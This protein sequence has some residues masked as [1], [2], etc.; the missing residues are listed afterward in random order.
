MRYPMLSTLSIVTLAAA[1][2]AA[3]AAP[4]HAQLQD[5]T[6]V[7]PTNDLP[8]PY[9]RV[10]PWGELPDP[11][12]PGAY[13]ERAAFIGADEGPDGN[14]YLLGRCLQNSC[15]GRSEPPLLKLDPSGRLLLSWGSGLFDFPHG[16]DLDDAGNVWVAD[17][18]GTRW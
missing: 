5:Q 12:V 13:N 8:N 2:L 3:A 17:Q 18:R 9:A 1:L 6:R 7:A 11:Y 10:H 16:L 15:T 4:A 14:I